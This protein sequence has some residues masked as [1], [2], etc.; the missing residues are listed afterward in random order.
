MKALKARVEE[1]YKQGVKRAIQMSMETYNFVEKAN[2]LDKVVEDAVKRRASGE[3]PRMLYLYALAF[4]LFEAKERRLMCH[5]VDRKGADAS[6][7]VPNATVPVLRAATLELRT[8]R[9][10]LEA[11]NKATFEALAQDTAI[12]ERTERQIREILDDFKRVGLIHL[13]PW[14]HLLILS[15][16]T[17]SLKEL[18]SVDA[19]SMAQL[20]ERMVAVM[21]DEHL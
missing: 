15:R 18:E 1:I 9:L 14:I 8:K 10:E 3:P 12:H 5:S 6:I 16:P 11:R 2:E 20:R 21:S 19:D 4:H 13:S 7:T 17:Q